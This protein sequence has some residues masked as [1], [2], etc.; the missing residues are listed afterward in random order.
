MSHRLCFRG[1]VAVTCAL[2]C[3]G[4][5]IPSAD[6]AAV[7]FHFT[8]EITAVTPTLGS[9]KGFSSGQT[10]VG[11][12][13]FDTTTPDAVSSPST[14]AYSGLTSFSVNMAGQAIVP[15]QP[16]T[17]PS[18]GI[19]VLNN[20]RAIQDRYSLSAFGTGPEST[21]WQFRQM[22]I[23][24]IDPSQSVFSNDSLPTSPP[25]LSSFAQRPA[26][27]A[28]TNRDASGNFL[29]FGSVDGKLTSLSLVPIPPAALLFGSGM[30]LLAA[31]NIIGRREHKPDHPSQ[32]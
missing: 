27:F 3:G 9:A 31:F 11:A 12:Y 13:T 6:S 16:S 30:M 7:T 15:T 4:L 28:F 2:L 18:N 23:D 32:G 1:I 10:F 24:L 21:G 22:R 25:S 14:G 8:G 29:G 17:N 26:S 20:E 19:F 5:S